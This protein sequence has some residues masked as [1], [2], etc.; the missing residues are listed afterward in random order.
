MT[1][2]SETP[3]RPKSPWTP[4]Y[5]V[6]TQGSGLSAEEEEGLD[7]LEPLPQRALE[8]TQSFIEP[9][10][11]AGTTPIDNPVSHNDDTPSHTHTSSHTL[12]EE[13]V[14]GPGEALAPQTHLSSPEPP[15]T[16]PLQEAI[17]K[18]ALAFHTNQQAFPTKEDVD[19]PRKSANSR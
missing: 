4:S 5:S 7:T 13:E 1:P 18:A 12:I 6:T 8:V 10:L 16:T 3:E 14:S 9:T 17:A 2:E 19:E 11:G 15:T